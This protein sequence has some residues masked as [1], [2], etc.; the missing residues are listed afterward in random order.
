MKL[1]SIFAYR[2]HDVPSQIRRKIGLNSSQSAL[3]DVTERVAED[4]DAAA[5]DQGF[6]TILSNIA[7]YD[8]TENGF[9]VPII[10]V[11]ADNDISYFNESSQI[12]NFVAVVTLDPL[13]ETRST[14]QRVIVVGYTSE[15]EPSFGGYLPPETKMFINDIYGLTVAYHTAPNGQRYTTD[16]S[17]RITDNHVLANALPAQT[18]G[19]AESYVLP[20]NMMSIADHRSTYDVGADEGV[21]LHTAQFRQTPQCVTSDM[22][23]PD[24][25]VGKATEGFLYGLRNV[26]DHSPEYSEFSHTVSSQTTSF[27]QQRHLTRSLGNNDFVSR[28]RDH[29]SAKGFSGQGNLIKSTGSFTLRDLAE[30]VGNPQ[31]LESQLA[32][33]VMQSER[34]LG[35]TYGA[36]N[37]DSNTMASIVSYDIA[38]RLSPIM[39]KHLVGQ[40]T[41]SFSTMDYVDG[42]L[43]RAM[44]VPE[45]VLTLDR[46]G[47][48]PSSLMYA[49]RDTLEYA[50]I[51]VVTKG[52][53]VP[54]KATVM[55]ALGSAIRVELQ[56]DGASA[57]EAFTYASFMSGRL[58]TTTTSDNQ[59]VQELAGSLNAF[60]EA[61]KDGFQIHQNTTA[62]KTIFDDD[63]NDTP[64]GNIFGGGTG[65]G[66]FGGASQQDDSDLFGDGNKYKF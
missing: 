42:M 34:D 7:T 38:N 13:N 46:H 32:N 37:W 53:R 66:L 3:D 22:V 51:N 27:F 60:T 39:A 58:N 4:G 25:F 65:E 61:L 17:F 50:L 62:K 56:V 23:S 54:V 44:I 36:D 2:V 15:C 14:E 59:Y 57:P 40:I 29:L 55:A 52:N 28:L 31:D 43:G 64:T 47:K 1:E 21:L 9:E 19:D 8:P 16:N 35:P 45:S 49:F 24:Q 33:S 48:V 41:F 30:C 26:S 20:D 11:G 10:N 18:F 12:Y 5:Q 6:R 63:Y